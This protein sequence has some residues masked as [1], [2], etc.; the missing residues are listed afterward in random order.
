MKKAEEERLAK[1]AELQFEILKLLA[2]RKKSKN[3]I[4]AQFICESRPQDYIESRLAELQEK[5]FIAQNKKGFFSL[6]KSGKS[7]LKNMQS[8]DKIN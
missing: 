2:K 3:E 4:I 1:I 8:V 5:D 6:T 7:E